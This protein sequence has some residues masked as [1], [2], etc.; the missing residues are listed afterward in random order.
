[1]K[2]TSGQEAIDLL[3][4]RYFRPTYSLR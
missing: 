2:V 3:L 4:H 1:L